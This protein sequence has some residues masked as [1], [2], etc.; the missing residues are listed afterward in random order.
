MWDKRSRC[1]ADVSRITI[2]MLNMSYLG[3]MAST[4]KVGSRGFYTSLVIFEIFFMYQS[5]FSDRNEA[6]IYICVARRLRRSG[7]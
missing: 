1:M 2:E 4:K 5:D 3:C 6:I 7:K